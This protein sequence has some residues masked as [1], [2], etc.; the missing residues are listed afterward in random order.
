MKKNIPTPADN[1]PDGK[2]D[3][4]YLNP[5][6]EW[7]NLSKR[8]S[9]NLSRIQRNHYFDEVIGWIKDNY[10][11]TGFNYFEAG[12]GYGKSV[13]AI[14][15]ILET[16]KID[17]H[18][19]GVDLS[20]AEIMNGLLHY[21]QEGENFDEA[22]KM[23]GLGNLQDLSSVTVYNEVSHSWDKEIKIK[24]GTVDLIFMEAVLQASGYGLNNYSEKRAAALNV[25]KELVRICRVG[26]KFMGRVSVF[27]PYITQEQGFSILREQNNWRFVPGYDEVL[28]MLR[29]SGFDKI[30]WVA[31]PHENSDKNKKDFVK[32]SFLA[33][34]L[35]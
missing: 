27:A 23:F 6:E 28:A 12:C 26:G 8:F 19:L 9:E 1:L 4:R 13:R 17:G 5:N 2:E 32:I 15:R 20:K 25:L 33:E 3:K 11:E 30:K 18:F 34:K 35:N 29:K 24:E 14:K 16:M 10:S 31:N 7:P 21:N 22:V